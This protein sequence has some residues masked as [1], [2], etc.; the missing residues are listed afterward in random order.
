MPTISIPT[1]DA[2]ELER[3][4]PDYLQGDRNHAKRVRWLI[5]CVTRQQGN[6]SNIA[7]PTLPSPQPTELHG[8]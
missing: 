4:A 5:D 8:G 2:A 3:L 1:E 7:E 6:G